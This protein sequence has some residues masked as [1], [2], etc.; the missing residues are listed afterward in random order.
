MIKLCK[1][2]KVMKAVLP[3]VYPKKYFDLKFSERSKIDLHQISPFIYFDK[4]HKDDDSIIMYE[5]QANQYLYLT[6]K[7]LDILSQVH[8]VKF[9]F[10]SAL[11][12]TPIEPE[13]VKDID[14][15]INCM[16]DILK[17]FANYIK[18]RMISYLPYAD[19]AIDHMPMI[20]EVYINDQPSNL[21]DDVIHIINSE[22]EKL[23]SIIIDTH[24]CWSYKYIG[25][26][27]I[28]AKKLY[29]VFIRVN[30]QYPLFYIFSK[31]QY[32]V[33]RNI[34]KFEVSLRWYNKN[35]Y[36]YNTLLEDSD[37]DD[38]IYSDTGFAGILTFEICYPYLMSY[39]CKE[40][41]DMKTNH[42]LIA[43]V[44]CYMNINRTHYSYQYP[45]YYSDENSGNKY[46][47]DFGILNRIISNTY[48]AD[49]IY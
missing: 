45:V 8:S 48:C 30:D 39:Y 16:D 42:F 35:K 29:K 27:P 15:N 41:N 7:A 13:S 36:D 12:D 11:P 23:T 2:G 47:Y 10:C 3:V 20:S 37:M 17:V 31:S 28:K 18:Y 40:L 32:K 6:K 25:D 49:S 14:T 5:T 26:K 9:T 43:I 19:F 33:F 4:D 21:F 22:I 24:A 34:D 46:E 44:S 1:N 38:Y